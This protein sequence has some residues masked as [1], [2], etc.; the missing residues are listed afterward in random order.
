[1]TEQSIVISFD[2]GTVGKVKALEQRIATGVLYACRPADGGLGLADAVGADALM[3]HWAYVTRADVDAAHAV[4]LAVAPW[5][6]SDPETLERLVGAGVDAI[7]T[8][9]PDVL[10]RVLDEGA[11]Q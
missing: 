1:M 3:P 11:A 8:D 9:H 4:G 6:T 7:G 2:H 10:R 5:A